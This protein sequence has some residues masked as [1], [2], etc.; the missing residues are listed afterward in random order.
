[1]NLLFD[2]VYYYCYGKQF[3]TLSALFQLNLMVPRQTE[4]QKIVF[5][6]Q[7]LL[8]LVGSK[9][10]LEK[11]FDSISVVFLNRGILH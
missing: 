9:L 8:N 3:H 5:T 6:T 1:M 4:G 11:L 7:L 10:H 2:N